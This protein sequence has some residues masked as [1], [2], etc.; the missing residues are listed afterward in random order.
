MP[1]SKSTPDE[2]PEAPKSKSKKEPDR[3]ALHDELEQLKA[4]GNK[5]PDRVAEIKKLL[6]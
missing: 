3:S 5:D 4:E 1:A 2:E 6:A